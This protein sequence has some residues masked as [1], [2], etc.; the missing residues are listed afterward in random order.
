MSHRPA[1]APAADKLSV[2]Q[3]RA[4]VGRQGLD[5]CWHWLLCRGMQWWCTS[6]ARCM[7]VTHHAQKSTDGGVDYCKRKVQFLRTQLEALTEVRLGVYA[8][9]H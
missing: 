9:T 1:A 3:R 7:H 5:R 8:Q 6:S 4:R 2:R